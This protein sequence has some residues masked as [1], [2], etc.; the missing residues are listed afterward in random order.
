M[1]VDERLVFYTGKHVKLKVLTQQ[2]IDESNWVGWFNDETMC[3]FNL[4][5]YYPNTFEAQT[6]ILEKCITPHKIQLGIVDIAKNEGLCGVVSLAKIDMLHRNCEIAGIMDVER[7]K[8]NPALFLEAN[9]IMIRHGFEQLG[10][11][12]IY[13]G[14]FHRYVSKALIRIFNF[15][16]EGVR[17]AQVFK[18]GE[19]RD[20]TMLGVFKDTVKY[21]EF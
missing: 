5:H 10:M 20:V 3:E 2:D 13:G 14:T 9:S 8:N 11:H 7:T 21:P 18:N 17:K 15:E 12:K 1:A 19:F 4:H 6:K 16:S